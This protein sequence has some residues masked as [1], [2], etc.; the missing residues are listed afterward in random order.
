MKLGFNTIMLQETSSRKKRPATERRVQTTS[1]RNNTIM[2]QE[3]CLIKIKKKP[4]ETRL[5]AS[6]TKK[7]MNLTTGPLLGDK[8]HQKTHEP[9]NKQQLRH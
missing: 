2:L 8:Q 3:T 1:I 5:Q 4:Q 9:D 7:I 6:S